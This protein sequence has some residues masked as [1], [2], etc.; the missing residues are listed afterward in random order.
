MMRVSARHHARNLGVLLVLALALLLAAGDV[1]GWMR[2]VLLPIRAR[3]AGVLLAVGQEAAVWPLLKHEPDPTLR[4]RLIHDLRPLMIGPRGL[5]GQLPKQDEVSIRRAL[6]LM[7]REMVGDPDKPQGS[8]AALRETEPPQELIDGLLRLY[9]DDPDAGIHAAAAWTLQG[10]GQES[11]LARI[12][13]EL[14]AS[15]SPAGRQWYVTRQGH[16]LAVIAGPAEFS[17]GSPP[18][19]ASRGSDERLHRCRIARSFSLAAWETT[20][21]QFQR[22]LRDTGRTPCRGARRAPPPRIAR[23]P[24]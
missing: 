1:T 4:T 19:E 18:S 10:Y 14:A 6:I 5:L 22:F 2:Q 17:M 13:R 20:V 24:A 16:T 23:R 3:S 15:I 21:E 8:R 9:R 12:D 11:A 7:A